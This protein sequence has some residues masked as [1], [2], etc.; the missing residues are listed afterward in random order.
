MTYILAEFA[1]NVFKASYNNNNQVAL[2]AR[3]RQ[4]TDKLFWSH[5]SY[6]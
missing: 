4:Y 6:Q 1:K 5:Y 2:L 3:C